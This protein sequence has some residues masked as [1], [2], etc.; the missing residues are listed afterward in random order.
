MKKKVLSAFVMATVAIS[1]FAQGYAGTTFNDRIG[2]GQDSI[3]V[4]NNF[5]LYREEFKNKNYEEAYNSWKVVMDKAP[6]AQIRIYQDGDIICQE[7]LKKETDAAKKQEIFNT[8]MNMHDTR[9]KLLDDLN[10]FATKLTTTTKGNIL[11][12]KAYDYYYYNPKPNYEEAYK[13]FKDG[14]DDLGENVEAYILY[15]FIQCSYNRFQNKK[16]DQTREDFI[17]DYMNTNDICERLLDEAKQYP[18]E[19]IPANPESE[20]STEWEERVVLSP[21]AEKI[22]KNYQPTQD[23][24][25]DL[26]V[27]SGAADCDA[28]TK[29]YEGK[30][31]GAK[32][33]LA[34][35]N[36]ILKILQNFEC[37]KSD[38]Y[39]KAADYAYEL[40]KTPNAALGKAAK[41]LKAGDTDG[42][43]K[44]L[45]EAIELETDATKKGKTAFSIAQILYSKG[46]ISGCRQYCNTA[47]RYIPSMGRAYLMIANCIVRSA[48]AASQNTDAMLTRSY[49]Y[50][51]ATDK[52]LKAM[53]VDPS[54][55]G[56]ANSQIANYRNGYYPKSEA[57]FKGLKAG[58]SVTVMGE[59]TTLRLR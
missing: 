46:N 37:D 13:L 3:D 24:C 5:S 6:L 44:Y 50:C 42:A 22:I 59:T 25:N 41:L 4:I 15:G 38:L 16:D 33:D 12:R 32:Q 21:E 52:C 9:I 17:N 45:Q 23:L 54:C 30:V 58:Q 39:Y 10:S 48:P 8:L 20:D 40:N 7:L 36:T 34:Q 19:V 28:L 51:L 14:I 29:I 27:K 57:F 55:A 18:A 43:M 53:A 47:L 2:H 11:C 35:L 1:A 31:E 49:Y 56:R 26:F